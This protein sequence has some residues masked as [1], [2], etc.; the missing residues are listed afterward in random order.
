MAEMHKGFGDMGEMM[1]C[2]LE[3]FVVGLQPWVH[4]RWA[5]L[6]VANML[7]VLPL[8]TTGNANLC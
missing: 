2:Y 4:P 7:I 5:H 3:V 6:S 8:P 1:A